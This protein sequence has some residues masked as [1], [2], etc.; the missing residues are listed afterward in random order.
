ADAVNAVREATGAGANGATASGAIG[1]DGTSGSTRRYYAI[2][3]LRSRENAAQD[4]EGWFELPGQTSDGLMLYQR[5]FRSPKNLYTNGQTL[6]QIES[7]FQEAVAK[8]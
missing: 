5:L 4:F 8:A 7:G 6:P 2:A 3:T 1:A